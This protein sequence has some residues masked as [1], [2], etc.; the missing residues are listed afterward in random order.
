MAAVPLAAQT[1]SGIPRVIDGDTIVLG[2]RRLRFHGID[3]AE[4]NTRAGQA[5]QKA[6]SEM[7]GGHSVSCEGHGRDHYNRLIAT[8]YVGT[9]NLNAA[10]VLAGYAR[11]YRYYSTDFIAGE[12]I[13]RRA[14]RG[15]WRAEAPDQSPRN[16]RIKGN[17]SD[18]GR[19][20]HT[21]SSPWY[22]RS[23]IDTSRGERWFC[24][25]GEARAAGWRAPRR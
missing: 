13:A 3:A 16:C 25:E 4:Q 10:L 18:N 11:A 1:L 2:E 23:R 19:I 9:Q 6:L 22:H 5:A 7:I 8:C 17:I 15:L 14:K 20:Y 24:T 12:E 21:P